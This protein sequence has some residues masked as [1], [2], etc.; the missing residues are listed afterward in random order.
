MDEDPRRTPLRTSSSRLTPH[1]SRLLDHRAELGKERRRIVRARRS[2]RV[3]LHAK[4]RFGFVAQALD[5]LVVKVDALHCNVHRQRL[6]VHCESVVLR[7][8]LYS[9]RAEVLDRLIAAAMA[10]FELEGLSAEG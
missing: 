1:V 4:H 5:G 3:I 9:S 10:E 7:G 6:G 2:F 8:N